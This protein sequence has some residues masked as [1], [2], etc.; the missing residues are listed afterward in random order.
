MRAADATC[1]AAPCATDG[2]PSRSSRPSSSATTRSPT[3][4]PRARSPTGGCATRARRRTSTSCCSA[5]ATT[6]ATRHCASGRRRRRRS[7]RRRRARHAGRRGRAVLHG[8]VAAR[9]GRPPVVV[10]T[11][12]ATNLETPRAI[13][14]D[15]DIVDLALRRR[16]ALDVERVA[17]RVRPGTTRLISVTCPHNPTGTMLDR[18]RPARARRARRALRRGAAR[19]R[20]VPRPDARRPAAARRDPVAPGD[21][22]L[23]DVEGLRASRPARGLGG[24]PR[25]GSSPRRCSRRRSRSVIC[26]ATIDE[27]IA[28]RVLADRDA[29]PAADPR[30]RPRPPRHRARLD[31]RPGPFEWIEPDGRRRRPGALPARGRRSTP[32]ASTTCC[33]RS[34]APTSARA[35]GSSSTTATSG[36]ASAGPQPVSWTAGL[37]ALTTAGEQVTRQV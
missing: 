30:R 16:L 32:S 26:G 21:Q 22:R 11:N 24:V 1:D 29:H 3:T 7:A 20:D 25:P 5:T 14:A 18:G 19:R 37:G 13:G 9:A 28:G 17:A 15:L 4:C 10:R 8:D 6:S 36:S 35:T 31:G 23:V 2:C 12:Y 34:T 33:S 27:A